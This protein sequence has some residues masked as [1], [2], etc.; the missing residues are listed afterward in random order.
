MTDVNQQATPQQDSN[1]MTVEEAFFKGADEGTNEGT[2]TP[3]QDTPLGDGT[4]SNTV[5]AEATQEKNDAKR[6]EYWQSQA[7]KSANENAQLKQQLSQVQQ[8]NVQQPAQAPVKEQTQEF[9]PPPDRP[10]RPSGFNRQE[11]YE[12][13]N[14]QSAR[15]LEE[16][17]QWRDSMTEYSS[18]KSE[19]SNALVR[20]QLD[21]QQQARVE[22]AKRAQAQ[23]QANK[24][25]NDVYELVQGEHGLSANEARD[26]IKD[27]SDPN[28]LNMKNLV[29]LYRLKK[30]SGQTAQ[31]PAGPSDAFKQQ[32]RAQQ[33]PSPMGVQPSQSNDPQ[34]SAEDGIMD[35]M[36]SDFKSKNPW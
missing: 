3:I 34:G 33:V 31:A 12:D 28:S 16:T 10:K 4:Q 23:Q 27:M 17:E 1:Q 14:S 19:Y 18:L 13:S 15:Y 36:I 35:S 29:Q 32:Q 2:G 26:F 21:T 20:E 25:I 5:D 30:G 8:M 7:D 9:P 24:E 22:D 11:A 6:F